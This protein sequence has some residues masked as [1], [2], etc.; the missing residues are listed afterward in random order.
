MSAPRSV[1]GVEQRAPSRSDAPVRRFAPVPAPPIG[2]TLAAP[3]EATRPT[4]RRRVP[5]AHLAPGLRVVPPGPEAA[6][7]GPLPVAAEALSRYQ[8]SRAAARSLVDDDAADG[9]SS[10]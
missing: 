5:Q 10:R 9:R 7:P 1:P 6:N 8:A 2:E 3:S 4:L